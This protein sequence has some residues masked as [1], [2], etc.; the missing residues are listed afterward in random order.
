M[1]GFS[2]GTFRIETIGKRERLYFYRALP[3]RN[4]AHGAARK[5]GNLFYFRH[6]AY[7]IHILGG[8]VVFIGIF[9]RAD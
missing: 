4:H 5:V 2:F 3:F 8:D 6:R 7:G 1:H 9:L